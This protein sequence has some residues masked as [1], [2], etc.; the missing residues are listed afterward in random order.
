MQFVNSHDASHA[1]T[2]DLPP[3]L[4]QHTA[5]HSPSQLTVAIV[6]IVD[7]LLGYHAAVMTL[8]LRQQTFWQRVG[9]LAEG[10]CRRNCMSVS[11]TG[12]KIQNGP[13]DCD[14]LHC[15]ALWGL[16]A[17]YLVVSCLV[18]APFPL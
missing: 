13:C 6:R 3:G 2:Q 15:P 7:V 16:F 14:S 11:F 17:V 12:R 9:L 8:W 1:T 10:E 4:H 5:R 18:G